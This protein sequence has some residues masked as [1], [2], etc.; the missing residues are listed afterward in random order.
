M[1][2]IVDAFW[3]ATCLAAVVFTAPLELDV[4]FLSLLLLWTETRQSKRTIRIGRGGPDTA[5]SP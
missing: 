1:R 5:F 4:Y 2:L 3:T